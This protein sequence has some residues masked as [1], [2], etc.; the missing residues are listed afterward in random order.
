[1]KKIFGLLAIATAVFAV[2]SCT[3]VAPVAATSNPVGSKCGVATETKIL[4]IY[5][6]E[7]DHGINKAAKE[8]G[9]RKISHVDVET[10]SIL[11]L[12]YTKTTTKVYGE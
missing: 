11:G 1:M 5:P 12:L 3:S 7:G 8:G 9:I 10:Y 6:F 2:S 4:G